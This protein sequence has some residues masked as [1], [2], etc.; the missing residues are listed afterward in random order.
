MREMDT[1]FDAVFASE[2]KMP[3]SEI[4]AW[5]RSIQDSQKTGVLR[6]I[7]PP[8][9]KY[10]WHVH[11]GSLLPAEPITPAGD[12]FAKFIPLS[13]H[14]LI[15]SNLLLQS[16]LRQQEHGGQISARRWDVEASSADPCVVK[17]KW[18][19]AAG[20]I[21]FNGLSS[22]PHSIFISEGLTIDEPGISAPISQRRN[23]PSCMVTVYPADPA[24]DAWQEIHL[25]RTFKSLCDDILARFASLAGHAMLDSFARIMAAFADSKNLDISIAKRELVNHE[26]FVSSRSAAGNYRVILNELLEHFS[27]VVGPRLLQSNLRE[28]IAA[29]SREDSQVL[30]TYD[31]LPEQ[32]LL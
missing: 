19:D 10:V 28:I 16:E 14:G 5:M 8:H 30:K 23:D 3:P 32:Y 20:S 22:L 31:L 25:R 13:P 1:I 18:E 12:V 7:E 9:G 29:F 21:L 15:H 11:R 4:P 17:L 24:L 26:F 27:V 2:R 6:L